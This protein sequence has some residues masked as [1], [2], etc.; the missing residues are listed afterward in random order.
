MKLARLYE[1][2]RRRGY[3]QAELAKRSGVAR[4]AISK[5]ETMRREAQ[6]ATARRLA[7]ALGVEVEDLLYHAEVERPPWG[8]STG[9]VLTAAEEEGGYVEYMALLERYAAETEGASR[10][11]YET[12]QAEARFR[13]ALSEMDLARLP[14]RSGALVRS[15]MELGGNLAAAGVTLPA[16]AA[17]SLVEALRRER[18]EDG[19]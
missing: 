18:K 4:D 6:G 9:Y 11:M 5:I 10:S 15:Y 17:K 1:Q 3:S 2:R 16:G 7:E 13:R 12:Y 19:R 14:G 8:K